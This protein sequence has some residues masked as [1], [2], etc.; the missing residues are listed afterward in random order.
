MSET[1]VPRIPKARLYQSVAVSRLR[2]IK[3]D[4]LDG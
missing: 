1:N 2:Q 4:S 3:L